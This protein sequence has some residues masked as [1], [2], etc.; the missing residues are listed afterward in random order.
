MNIKYVIVYKNQFVVYE[1]HE[2]IILREIKALL[3]EATNIEN[4]HF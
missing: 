2:G 3:T 4:A 1:K